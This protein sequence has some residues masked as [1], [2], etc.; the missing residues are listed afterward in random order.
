[1]RAACAGPI[2]A[3]DV[4]RIAGWPSHAARARRVAE[5]L[6]AEGILVAGAAGELSLT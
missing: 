2:P 1:V 5:A 6:V 4:A 3:A